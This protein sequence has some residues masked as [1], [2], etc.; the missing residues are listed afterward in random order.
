M[1]FYAH[2][3]CLPYI[4]NHLNRVTQASKTFRWYSWACCSVVGVLESPFFCSLNGGFLI[5][6]PE[7]S[8]FLVKWVVEVWHGHQGLDGEQDGSDLECWRPLGLEDIETDSSELIDIWVVDLGSE[9]HLWWHHWVLVWQE[10]FAVEDTTFVRGVGWACN[11]DVEMS[12][13]VL[14]WFSVDSDD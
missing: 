10:K 9:Q 3:V 5:G 12:E 11:L 14:T 6:F 13:V 7:I 1:I 2:F 8:N 4:Y